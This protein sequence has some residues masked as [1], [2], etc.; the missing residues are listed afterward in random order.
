MLMNR[1]NPV[2]LPQRVF[3][4]LFN[5][6]FFAVAPFRLNGSGRP[7]TE[8]GNLPLDITETDRDLIVTATVPG[9]TR[10]QVSIE[11][12]DG[13]L[14]I[15]AEQAQESEERNEKYHRRERR[16]G[17]LTRMLR[18]PTQVQEDKAQATLKDGVLTLTL[19]K[20]EKPQP[21]KIAVT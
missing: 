19:P 20:L 12:A 13:V 9:F 16:T 1:T 4:E 14:R 3:E 21:R 8:A 15:A 11:V 10:D 18:L 5:E 6:P 7:T 2:G 17:A